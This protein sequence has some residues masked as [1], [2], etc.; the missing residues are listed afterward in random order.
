MNIYFRYR[1][2]EI[3]PFLSFFFIKKHFTFPTFIQ[4]NIPPRAE[5]SISPAEMYMDHLQF[6]GLARVLLSLFKKIK[7][8]IL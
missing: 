8:A 3:H 4:L 5:I 2:S 6:A 7:L 1:T